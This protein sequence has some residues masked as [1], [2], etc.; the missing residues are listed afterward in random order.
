MGPLLEIRDVTKR[1]GGVAAVDGVSLDIAA[2]EFFALLGPSGCGKTTLMRMVAGFEA[3]DAGRVLIGGRDMAGVPPHE[4]PVNMMVQSYALFPH[5]SV[6]ENIAFG[7]RRMGMPRADIEARVAEMLRLVQLDGFG[8]RDPAKLSGGQRQRVALARA[9]ARR[10]A[11]L[12]LDEPL[13]ALD[14]KLREETQFELIHVQRE[15]GTSFMLVT[16]DQ[17]EAMAM[18]ARVGVMRA[19]KLEQTGTPREVYDAPVSRFVA[20]FVGEINLLEATVLEPAAAGDVARLRL[21]EGPD[22]PAL[23]RCAAAT[24]AGE[25]VALA[26]R[27]E[28]I[29]LA[30]PGAE[31]TPGLR[32]EI[33]EI[34]FRGDASLARVR[35]ASGLVLRA[36]LPAAAMARLA[37]ARGE[38]VEARVAPDAGRVLTR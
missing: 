26:V 29:E 30:R 23:G 14:R 4:R 11:L 5:M 10:P 19:G 15:L 7:L 31:A 33:A 22:I 3:P 18:A 35:L 36:S 6:A 17:N 1:F 9:L 25:A 13:A 2:G 21:A 32:G 24:R 28:A 37:L 20:Q 34:V 38:A 12:L 16:H 27:P 8:P